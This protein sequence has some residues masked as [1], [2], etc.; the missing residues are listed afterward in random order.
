MI[1]MP[2]YSSPAASSLRLLNL[3]PG[4]HAGATA[5]KR[6]ARKRCTLEHNAQAHPCR[7]S[8]R[9][10]CSGCSWATSCAPARARGSSE[11]ASDM[12]ASPRV[13]PRRERYTRLDLLLARALHPSDGT[14]VEI[15]RIVPAHE[16]QRGR[17]HGSGKRVLRQ[18][19]RTHLLSTLRSPMAAGPRYAARTGR[20]GFARALTL[21]TPVPDACGGM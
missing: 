4:S 3:V 20:A 15:R 6:G 9:R 13:P 16:R 5:H 18:R 8:C 19:A 14:G 1:W 10:C 21:R 12:R 2:K 17:Q 11:R 7:C